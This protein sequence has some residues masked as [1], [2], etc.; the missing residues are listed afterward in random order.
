ML[1]TLDLLPHQAEF[2]EDITSRYIALVGGF[3]SGKTAAFCAKGLTL[4]MHNLGY[5][6]V[7]MSP[8]IAMNKRELLPAFEALLMD[9]EVKYTQVKSQDRFDI[10]VGNK[11][12]KV[13]FLSIENHMKARSMNLAVFGMDELDTVKEEIAEAAWITMTSRL[14]KG[15]VFQGFVTTTPEGYKFTYKYFVEEMDEDKHLI[16]A[17]TSDNIFL[18]QEY[19]DDMKKRFPANLVDAYLNG[20]FVNLTSG[21]VYPNF[22]RKR[23]HTDLKIEDFKEHP[24]HVGID[25]NVGKMVG[26]INIIDNHFPYTLDEITGEK[27]TETLIRELKKR[28]P[29]KKMYAYPDSS[30]KSEHSNASETDISLLISNGI[31]CFY[32]PTNPLVKNRVNSMNAMLYNMN[33]EVRWRINT[34]KCPVLV[35]SLEQQ[36]YDDN[37][38][39]DKG[40]DLDHAVDGQGYFIW[41]RFPLKKKAEKRELI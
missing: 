24:L 14:R 4:A 8:T 29:N 38:K 11:V 28:F 31:Q 41:Y 16:Q 2:V 23:N 27:N 30:G 33:E 12:C 15:N 5:S 9:Q 21:S 3:G 25:F 18:P 7:L 37:G 40:S 20:Q 32:N 39:P 19:I 10:R 1:L 36:A 17:K 22:D 13:Y 6:M 26:I 35:K 34:L